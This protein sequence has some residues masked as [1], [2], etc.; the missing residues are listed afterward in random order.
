MMNMNEICRILKD[1]YSAMHIPVIAFTIYGEIIWQSK[2]AS[3]LLKVNNVSPEE[4]FYNIF[5]KN[6]DSGIIN[7][8]FGGKFNKTKISDTECFIAE[9]YVNEQLLNFFAVPKISD[10]I[11]ENDSAVR[12]YISRIAA[13]CDNIGFFIDSDDSSNQL[14]LPLLDDII[15]ICCRMTGRF[16]TLSIV[17][18]LMEI[19]EVKCKEITVSD[20]LKNLAEGCRHAFK[21]KIN[22]ELKNE[23]N[24]FIIADE[25]MLNYFILTL[26]GRYVYNYKNKNLK[27]EINCSCN[28]KTVKIE[29]SLSSDNNLLSPEITKQSMGIYSDFLD[30]ISRKTG[31]SYHIYAKKIVISVKA[32]DNLQILKLKSSSKSFVNERF[33]LYN[34]ILSIFE[35]EI[36]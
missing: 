20:F 15:N 13:I 17:K 11:N 27:L 3:D 6:S 31:V 30:E 2:E 34:Q 14:V 10:Y 12:S 23:C 4:I 8:L 32:A 29:L 24:V 26:L 28:S 1:V 9:L 35:D 5:T 18:E 33:S 16:T 25:N 7:I 19:S 22:V 21:D 36:Y